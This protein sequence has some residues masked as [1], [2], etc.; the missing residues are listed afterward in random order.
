MLKTRAHNV[1]KIRL[2]YRSAKRYQKAQDVELAIIE[3]E[4]L[5]PHCVTEVMFE[6]VL[7]ESSDINAR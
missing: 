1:Q 4:V 7:T 5:Y 6:S 3:S 2:A